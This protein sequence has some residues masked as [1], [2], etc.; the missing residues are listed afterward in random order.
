MTYRTQ[1]AAQGADLWNPI[2]QQVVAGAAA[3]LLGGAQDDLAKAML[4]NPHKAEIALARYLLSKGLTVDS[5]DAAID[6]EVNKAA[7]VTFMRGV[8]K[9][10]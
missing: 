7:T 1:A 9:L 5:N 10:P 4:E 6:T 8:F 2:I 3:S